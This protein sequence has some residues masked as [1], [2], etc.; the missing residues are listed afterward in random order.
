MHLANPTSPRILSCTLDSLSLCR[1]FFKC[2]DRGLW[3]AD[4][5]GHLGETREGLWFG[6]QS[7]ISRLRAQRLDP[8]VQHTNTQWHTGIDHRKRPLKADATQIA[9]SLCEQKGDITN[10]KK[11]QKIKKK[12][13][14]SFLEMRHCKT[15]DSVVLC[16]LLSWDVNQLFSRYISFALFLFLLLQKIKISACYYKLQE[17]HFC[18]TAI[19]HSGAHSGLGAPSFYLFIYLYPPQSWSV[20]NI[21]AS[22][23]VSL[24][25]TKGKYLNFT[26]SEA[27]RWN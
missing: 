10:L 14:G 9:L 17:L 21:W 7:N 16:A 20:C 25:G 18:P 8:S 19:D 5:P 6:L 11:K 2:L 24:I 4:A 1:V 15:L 23:D 13:R 3:T 22:T 26:E 12:N 27:V